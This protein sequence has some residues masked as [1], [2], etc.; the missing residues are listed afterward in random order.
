M[1]QI[2]DEA[3]GLAS[4]RLLELI[5]ENSVDEASSS[6]DG[7]TDFVKTPEFGSE[8]GPDGDSLSITELSIFRRTAKLVLTVKLPSPE[9][10]LCGTSSLA[11]VPGFEDEPTVELE[12]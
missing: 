3:V 6:L 11:N 12:S 1:L 5:L 4:I 9:S 7:K 2:F 10:D 8:V